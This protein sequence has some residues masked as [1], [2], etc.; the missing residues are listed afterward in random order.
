MRLVTCAVLVLGSTS[1]ILPAQGRR[2]LPGSVLMGTVVDA[3]TGRGLSRAVVTVERD[4]QMRSIVTDDRGRYLFSNLPAGHYAV[5]AARDRYVPGSFGQQH[6]GG[7]GLRVTMTS[8]L[9]MSDIDI[10]LWA[11]AVISGDVRTPLGDPIPTV[12]VTAYRRTLTP[13]HS[14]LS[15]AGSADTDD[16]GRY[17]IHGLVPGEYVVGVSPSG[18]DHDV[19]HGVFAPQLF[20]SVEQ[21]AWAMAV[22]AVPGVEFG[23]VNFVLPLVDG[24]AV[25]GRV[26]PF[27]SPDED[28]PPLRI[29]IGAPRETFVDTPLSHR[30][31]AETR[32]TDDG[33]F[34]FPAVPP[35]VWE[36]EAHGPG[37][38]TTRQLVRVSDTPPD[39][40]RLQMQPA[41]TVEGRVAMRRRNGRPLDLSKPVRVTFEPLSES[42]PDQLVR[43]V[44]PGDTFT[45]DALLP[46]A[47]LVTVDDLPQ[48]VTLE[49]I[50]A[51]GIDV[52]DR[53]LMVNAGSDK[54]TVQVTLSDTITQVIGTVARKD[55]RGDVSSTVIAFPSDATL[56]GPHRRRAVR[57]GPDGAFVLFNLPPGTYILAAV[58]GRDEIGWESPDRLARWR[59]TGLAVT[60][61]DSE[62]RVV[63]VPIVTR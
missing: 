32:V 2:A 57:V 61:R 38:L 55:V 29:T 10:R 19:L 5:M 39:E 49:E 20:P 11:P 45:V 28:V 60:L 9:W 21:A 47:Y 1:A 34:V 26:E 27:S 48:G 54:V 37:G 17:R 41:V 59:T 31:I 50:S 23:A 52:L 8:G 36:V 22:E 7:S 16:L 46:G 56:T 33:D 35:G 51:N 24:V 25:T 62:I 6:A 44:R 4:G 53:P 14:R 18:V 12:K 3:E 42:Q 58:A 63:Q 43:A 13:T 40:L 30:R 15:P